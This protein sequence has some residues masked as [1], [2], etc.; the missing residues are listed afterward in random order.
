MIPAGVISGI[1]R[2]RKL[3]GGT[4][5]QSKWQTSGGDEG[6]RRDEGGL[7]FTSNALPVSLSVASLG[8][9]GNVR[10]GHSTSRTIVRL[11]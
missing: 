7:P 4:A 6:K 8:G 1:E 10:K 9:Q 11:N 2:A 5:G 3:N